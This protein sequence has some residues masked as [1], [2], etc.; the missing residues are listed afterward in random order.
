V[1]IAGCEA[2]S[3]PTE[4][5]TFPVTDEEIASMIDPFLLLELGEISSSKLSGL[6]DLGK[7]LLSKRFSPDMSGGPVRGPLEPI[8]FALVSSSIML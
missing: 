8:R 1:G 6:S 4:S 2:N 3:V 5:V 7:K